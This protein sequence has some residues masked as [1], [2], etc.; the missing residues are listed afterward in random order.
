MGLPFLGL[1]AWPP[2]LP[3]NVDESAVGR[4]SVIDILSDFFFIRHVGKEEKRNLIFFFCPKVAP[5]SC[6]LC[7]A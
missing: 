6:F 1:T 2:K 3:L 5:L 7:D 4:K